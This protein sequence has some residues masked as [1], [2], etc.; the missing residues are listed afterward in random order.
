MPAIEPKVNTTK[1]YN[2]LIFAWNCF[3]INKNKV[4]EIIHSIIDAN[5]SFI[6]NVNLLMVNSSLSVFLNL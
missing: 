3:T 6:F 5:N 4:N 2:G 1:A